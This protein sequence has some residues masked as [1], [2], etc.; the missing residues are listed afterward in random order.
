MSNTRQL[1][2][3]IKSLTSLQKILNALEIV[4]TVK[5]QKLK[6]KTEALRNFLIDF[7]NVVQALEDQVNIFDFDKK[8]RDEWWKRLIILVS[9]DK[10]LCWPINSKL[11]KHIANK[12]TEWKEKVDIFVI[13]KKGLDFFIRDKRNVV[14]SL[15]LKDDFVDQELLPLYIY[16]KESIKQKKYAKIKIY[17]NFFKTTLTQIPLRFKIYPLD[18]ESFDSFLKDIDIKLEKISTTKE[19]WLEIEP[20]KTILVEK[21]IQEMIRYIVYSAVTQNKT[22]EHASRMFA[23]KNAKDN[24]GEIIKNIN[25]LYNK[26]RQWKITQEI[27]EIGNA[28]AA[29]EQN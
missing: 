16:I 26:V 9:T 10:W 20:S 29:L 19:Q 18:K 12:Y 8:H 3:Q 7:L 2:T 15:Q 23:M 6:K 1:R 11:I 24:S 22:G 21:L 25:T 13:G 28:K 4:S 5:L 27:S 17:F 14:G